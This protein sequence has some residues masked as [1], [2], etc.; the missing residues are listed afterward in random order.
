MSFHGEGAFHVA[1]KVAVVWVSPGLGRGGKRGG[2]YLG[3]YVERVTGVGGD[4][5]G[6][7]VFVDDGDFRSGAHSF[8]TLVFEALDQYFRRGRRG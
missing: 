5:V 3:V 2:A 7:D 4:G 6:F 1:V 8:P